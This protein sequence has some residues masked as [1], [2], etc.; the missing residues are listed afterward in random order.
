VSDAGREVAGSADRRP[1]NEQK[2]AIGTRLEVKV[3]GAWLL[4]FLDV[5]R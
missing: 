1:E 4:R 3:D 5:L 2:I